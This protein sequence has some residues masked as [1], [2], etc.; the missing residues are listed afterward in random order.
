MFQWLRNHLLMQGMWVRSLVR[1]LRSHLLWGNQTQ[2]PQL[3]SWHDAL[4]SQH[5]QKNKTKQ[6]K[7]QN[8]KTIIPGLM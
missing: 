2:V 7:K 1:E 4:K 8:Q 3:E 6:P 5:R